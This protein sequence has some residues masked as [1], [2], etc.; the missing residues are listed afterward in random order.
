MPAP[1]LPWTT[2]QTI[3]KD[4][5]NA[6]AGML[7]VYNNSGVSL[8]VGTYVTFDPTYTSGLGVKIA[9][10]LFDQR[11]LGPVMGATIGIGG[12]GFVYAPGFAQ[13]QAY[14]TGAVIFGHSLYTYS[15]GGYLTG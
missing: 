5:L 12:Y 9:S 3:D 2:G 6:T 4:S 15:A 1:I 10:S 11:A 14:V 7:Y 13:A 8:P